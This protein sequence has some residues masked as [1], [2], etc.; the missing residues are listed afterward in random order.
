VSSVK[1]GVAGAT[2]VGL[3]RL[4]HGSRPP[5]PVIVQGPG[6]LG[7][8]GTRSYLPYHQ[9]FTAAGFAVLVFDYRGFGDSEGDATVLDPAAQIE[10]WLGAVAYCA[11]H[12]ELDAGRLG[13]FG[14]GGTGG[15]NALEVAARERRVRAVVAQVPI[16]D[17]GDWLRRQRTAEEWQSFRAQVKQH[18]TRLV[19]ARGEL[20]IV[21]GDRAGWK[22]DIEG[23]VPE[24]VALASADALIRYRPIDAVG[25]IAPGATMIVAVADDEV[26]PT[27]HA[28]ALF[29]A[30]GEPKRL[31]L[32]R[33]TTHYRAY[34]DHRHV[35][36]PLMVDWFERHVLGRADGID[37]GPVVTVGTGS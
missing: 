11:D 3:L 26:T 9:A 16:A 1:F 18:P 2:L 27:D 6:W 25:E 35:V 23:R 32:Q 31:V 20:A 37:H 13:V 5:H 28:L 8:A 12:P 14:S 17:G 15:G 24:R 33:G 30:A 29:E 19:R 7:L 36:L 34:V 21:G 4:P 10:D 22:Q